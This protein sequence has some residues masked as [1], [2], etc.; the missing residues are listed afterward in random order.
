MSQSHA[1][2]KHEYL[3]EKRKRKSNP[4]S[5]HLQIESHLAWKKRVDPLIGGRKTHE[6]EVGYAI[7]VAKIEK[8]LLSSQR[9]NV[10]DEW[11]ASHGNSLS[12]E[13]VNKQRHIK[14]VIAP[15]LR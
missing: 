5:K 14:C 4:V 7:R 2:E 13:K 9:R 11:T 1:S 15:H 6:D 10:V 8:V 12:G 3:G